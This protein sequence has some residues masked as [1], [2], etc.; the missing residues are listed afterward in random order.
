MSFGQGETPKSFPQATISMLEKGQ[1]P[2]EMLIEVCRPF[3]TDSE[4][5]VKRCEIALQNMTYSDPE[6]SCMYRM[7]D[8]VTC[9][10]GC[11]QPK[12]HK[13]LVGQERG[14]LS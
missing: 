12:I 14:F 3:C 13:H 11:V 7:R 5:K 9:I 6:K 1:D 10:E 2:K 4:Q 8:W